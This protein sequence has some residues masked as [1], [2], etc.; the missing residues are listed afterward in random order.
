MRFVHSDELGRGQDG[1]TYESGRERMADLQRMAKAADNDAAARKQ[2]ADDA[3]KLQAQA[4]DH[5]Q[6]MPA[7]FE[8]AKAQAVSLAQMIEQGI[9]P[10]D[11]VGLG[12]NYSGD[13]ANPGGEGAIVSF[14]LTQLSERVTLQLEDGREWVTQAHSF[15]PGS[16]CRFAINWKMH[17]RP[18]LAQLAAAVASQ[19]AARTA[20][21][22]T[23]AQ[24]FASET[25]RLTAEYPYLNRVIHG[26]GKEAAQNVRIMLKRSFPGV[27]FGVTSDYSNISIKWTDGPTDAQ[28]S[29]VVARFD[30]G[31]SDTQTDYFYTERTA[32]SGLFGG[33]QYLWT[34]RTESP[35]LVAAVL[36]QFM[37]GR[38][39]QATADDYIKCQGVFDWRTGDDFTRRQFTKTLRSTP[40]S[41]APKA[42]A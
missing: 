30:I 34:S 13:A 36:A 27:K 16:G 35:E 42:K 17:G 9:K 23:Q 12:I 11:L 4:E 2:A 19:K 5:A 3:A 14:E 6:A 29:E 41:A 25:E 38:A 28:V 39:L 26:G 37:D 40:G 32:W 24:A 15:N 33:V 1:G 10:A 8:R 21:E 18:Y 20:K 7:Q 31:R 22:E